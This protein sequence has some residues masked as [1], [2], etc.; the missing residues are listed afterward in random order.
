M[1]NLPKNYVRLNEFPEW[2]TV[3][4]S[5]LYRVTGPH[6]QERVLLGAELADGIRLA[7]GLWRIQPD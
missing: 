3:D 2:F 5:R 4:E 1:L 6:G 7:D